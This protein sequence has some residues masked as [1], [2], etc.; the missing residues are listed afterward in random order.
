MKGHPKQGTPTNFKEKILA[1]EKIHTIRSG[2]HWQKVVVMVNLGEAIL[3]LREWSG[4][5][6][7]SKQ[8]EIKQFDKLGWQPIR[9][10][11]LGKDITS[12]LVLNTNP[13]LRSV[14]KFLNL[15]QIQTLAK[16]DGLST[17]DFL[18]WFKKDMEAGG[19]LHFTD[20]RY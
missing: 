16:N 18:A 4:A 10:D 2:I 1:G 19:I 6:Y 3:S 12:F 9:V 17:E 11:H 14:G 20:Y 7:A 13:V 5:P 15:D 8:V